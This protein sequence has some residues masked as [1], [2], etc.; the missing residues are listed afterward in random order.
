MKRGIVAWPRYRIRL[1][2]RHV[3]VTMRATHCN[4]LQCWGDTG[5]YEPSKESSIDEDALFTCRSKEG[6]STMTAL[7]SALTTESS[8]TK[9]PVSI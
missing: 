2:G 4:R 8:I 3:S 1:R 9:E 7:R 5:F 6:L